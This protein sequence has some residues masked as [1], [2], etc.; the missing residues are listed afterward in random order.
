[1]DYADVQAAPT[2]ESNVRRLL[3]ELNAFK[4][5]ASDVTVNMSG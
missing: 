5:S 1:M 4:E 3:E 2:A